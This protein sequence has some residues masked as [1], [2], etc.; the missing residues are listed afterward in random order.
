LSSPDVLDPLF[1]PDSLTAHGAA[2]R[3][4]R[5]P[6]HEYLAIGTG[7]DTDDIGDLDELH[8]VHPGG[9]PSIARTCGLVR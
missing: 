4:R 1:G 8:L 7:L 9:W 6:V 2:A 5:V 3:E